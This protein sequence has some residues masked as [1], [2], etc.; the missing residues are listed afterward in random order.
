M[1][2]V[3]VKL[4]KDHYLRNSSG[5]RSKGTPKVFVAYRMSEPTSCQFRRDLED[6]LGES[7]KV[8]DGHVPPGVDWAPE[9]RKRI[10]SCRLLVAD[11]SGPSRE[12]LF[13]LGFGGSK[14]L[15][16]V[17]FDAAARQRLPRWITSKQVLDYSSGALHDVVDS[18]HLRVAGS[19]VTERRPQAVPGQLAF[20]SRRGS[21][22]FHDAREV[23]LQLCSEYDTTFTEFLE[24][25]L[26]SPEDLRSALR[27]SIVV[28]VIDGQRQDYAV[29]YLLGDV[30]G[31]SPAGAGSKKGE[32]LKR[33]GI[34][35]LKE[36]AS[37]E[38]LADS[39]R[40]ISTSQV[41]SATAEEMVAPLKTALDRYRRLRLEN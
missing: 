35:L 30:V 2:I 19:R 40:R 29:H 38:F 28:G 20:I 12:V 11:I 1:D 23:V 21:T 9:V 3:T 26:Q 16:P 39:L 32:S 33:M 5:G 24:E 15:L 4:P 27:A 7:V 17:A 36:R 22:W 37:E 10:K 34:A 18:V 31:R 13:E 14:D 8:E 6:Q 41:V 25:D